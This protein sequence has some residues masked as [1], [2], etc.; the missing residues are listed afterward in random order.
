MPLV[1]GRHEFSNAINGV[2][3]L[4]Q[5]GTREV[6][7]RAS[8]ELLRNRFGSNDPDGDTLAFTRN[9]DAIERAAAMKY[10]A[11]R[12]E[13]GGDPEVVVTEWDMTSPLSR[14]I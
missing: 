11:G 13:A 5:D 6:A 9:R 12:T 8:V 14:K 7:C 2:E 1:R 10:L 3:F 4:M